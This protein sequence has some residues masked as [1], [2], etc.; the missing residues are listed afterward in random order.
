MQR[1]E[2]CWYVLSLQQ[3]VRVVLAG[4][5]VRGSFMIALLRLTL[6]F[7]LDGPDAGAAELAVQ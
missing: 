3:G 4:M 5:R 2:R 7:H 6:L 1:P